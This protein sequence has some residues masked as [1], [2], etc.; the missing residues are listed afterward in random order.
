MN[1][2]V[3]SGL[4]MFLFTRSTPTTWCYLLLAAICLPS[5]YYSTKFT[6]STSSPQVELEPI[7]GTKNYRLYSKKG[8]DDKP[9][10]DGLDNRQVQCVRRG[11]CL[12]AN[13]TD[14]TC[15]GSKLPYT[16]TSLGLTDYRKVKDLDEVLSAYYALRHVPKCW[17]VIQVSRLTIKID[18]FKEYMYVLNGKLAL[19]G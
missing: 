6:T 13:S 18:M 12:E 4:G 8:K 11:H 10:F 5:G 9:W 19:L 15:L 3:N 1:I 16:Q 7:N 2:N 17:A 14:N